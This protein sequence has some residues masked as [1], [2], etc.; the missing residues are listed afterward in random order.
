MG[1]ASNDNK[2][3]PSYIVELSNI[4][5]NG[6]IY[7]MIASERMPSSHL[8]FSVATST[9]S[10]VYESETIHTSGEEEYQEQIFVSLVSGATYIIVSEI[11]LGSSEDSSDYG[12][13]A[14]SQS[15]S[16]TTPEGGSGFNTNHQNLDG[17]A[18]AVGITGGLIAAVCAGCLGCNRKGYRSNP[19]PTLLPTSKVAMLAR[20]GVVPST[21]TTTVPVYDGRVKHNPAPVRTAP[22]YTP[23]HT[24]AV[25][26]T[27][28]ARPIVLPPCPPDWKMGAVPVR[29]V[30]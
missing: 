22:I 18:L 15:T 1:K 25:R 9:G 11:S 27:L 5:T 30:I 2:E 28:P 23:A 21:W 26:T 20:G 7:N 3:I 17:V 19:M 13:G 6:F 4:T 24:T 16:F 8:D 12:D 10:Y 14:S 29:N